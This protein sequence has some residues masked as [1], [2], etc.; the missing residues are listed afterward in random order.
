MTRA[1]GKSIPERR[2]PHYASLV[3]PVLMAAAI[4]VIAAQ[5]WE[6]R[7][8]SVVATWKHSA[9]LLSWSSLGTAA[10]LVVLFGSVYAS[11]LH[12]ASPCIVCAARLPLDPS[13]A[14]ERSRPAFRVYHQAVRRLG[15]HWLLIFAAGMLFLP[16]GWPLNTWTI[17]FQGAGTVLVLSALRHEKLQ[18]WCPWCRHNGG[19][20]EREPDPDPSVRMPA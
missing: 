12:D 15:W 20:Y 6:V 16:P 5:S 9:P 4:V 10:F 2:W 17:A 18:P 14:A 3:L 19:E 13:A 11:R 7:S 1:T 8:W